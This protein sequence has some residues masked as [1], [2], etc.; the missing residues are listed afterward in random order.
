MEAL[1]REGS[2][3]HLFICGYDPTH[4]GRGLLHQSY[5]G[6]R[7]PA[8]ERHRAGAADEAAA[9]T[10]AEG[11]RRAAV[12]D[13]VPEV[14]CITAMEAMHAGLP[15]ISSSHAAPSETCKESGSILLPLKDGRLTKRLSA[16]LCIL[17]AERSFQQACREAQLR[18]ACFARGVRCRCARRQDRCVVRGSL[19]QSCQRTASLHR[20]ERHRCPQ[21]VLI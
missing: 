6:I 9:G 12:P 15:F 2:K 17:R 1:E 19:A 3:G 11:V 5:D 8:P 10:G 18:R 21:S 20:D 7:Q 14:S 4:A 13:R 16:W